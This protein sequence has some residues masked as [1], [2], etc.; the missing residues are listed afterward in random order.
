[1]SS[2]LSFPLSSDQADEEQDKGPGVDRT[3]P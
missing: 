1:M 3:G 2:R